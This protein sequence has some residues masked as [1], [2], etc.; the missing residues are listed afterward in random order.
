MKISEL[1]ESRGKGE[2]T[3]SQKHALP[4]GSSAGVPPHPTGPATA[5]DKY[6]LGVRMAG[7][8]H[9][10]HPYPR[11]G[12]YADDMVM[13]GYT[14]ADN[15]IID[16]SM[17][18]FGFKHNKPAHGPSQETDD[19]HKASPIKGAPKFKRK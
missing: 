7:A 1:F 6:R 10:H 18:D 2:W 11:H 16:H 12:Q 19:V 15:E 17:K 13:I 14:D 8:P 5:Y 3:D 9:D 4:H